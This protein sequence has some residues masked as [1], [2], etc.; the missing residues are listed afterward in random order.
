MRA[1]RKTNGNSQNVIQ[2]IYRSKLPKIII[3]FKTKQGKK[4][5]QKQDGEKKRKSIFHGN[6]SSQSSKRGKKMLTKKNLQNK[7][8]TTTTLYIF[9]IVDGWPITNHVLI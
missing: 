9:V 8:Q 1:R 7:L 2:T 3:N 6:E 5:K 4:T